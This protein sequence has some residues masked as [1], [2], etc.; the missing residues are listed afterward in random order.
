MNSDKLAEKVVKATKQWS[1]V[2]M[3]KKTWM[4]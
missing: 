4:P 3:L 2:S 1:S